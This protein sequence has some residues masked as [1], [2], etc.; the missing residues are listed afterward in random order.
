MPFSPKRNDKKTKRTTLAFEGDE[1]ALAATG[2]VLQLPLFPFALVLLAE[3]TPLAFGRLLVPEDDDDGVQEGNGDDDLLPLLL[4][5][6]GLRRDGEEDLLGVLRPCDGTNS[7][8][9]VVPRSGKGEPFVTGLR[10]DGEERL[11]DP[12][13][14][15]GERDSALDEELAVLD[16]FKGV[17]GFLLRLGFLSVYGL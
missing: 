11:D 12:L 6:D 13:V 9:A 15:R 5:V 7:M 14:D 4:R 8:F 10:G 16:D 3:V 2:G 1:A 17:A